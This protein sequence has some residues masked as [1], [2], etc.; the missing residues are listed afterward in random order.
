MKSHRIILNQTLRFG[1][2]AHARRRAGRGGAGS[3]G[4][5]GEAEN[6]KRALRRVAL[7]VTFTNHLWLVRSRGLEPP[8]RLQD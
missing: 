2:G 4:N 5:D 1:A 6:K 8:P 3:R 7:S